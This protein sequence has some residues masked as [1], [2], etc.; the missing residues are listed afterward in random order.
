MYSRLPSFILGFHGCD[1]SV[2]ARL[3]SGKQK[4]DLS[5]NVYDW[6]GSGMYFWENNPARAL[7]FAKNLQDKRRSNKPIIKNPAV[8]GAVIDLGYCLNL[9]DAKF[10]AIVREGYE[11]LE[12]TSRDTDTPMPTNRRDEKTGEILL[13]DLDCAVINAVHTFRAQ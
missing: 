11:I 5:Q 4:Q 2:A 7:E 13:R 12:Q 10:L 1:R 6:L 9:L 3:I 8:V